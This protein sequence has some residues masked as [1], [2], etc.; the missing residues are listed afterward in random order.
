M[1]KWTIALV[2]LLAAPAPADVIDRVAI[3]VGRHVITE[4]Q[5]DEEILVTAFLNE[6]PISRDLPSRRAAADRLIEQFLIQ[7]ELETS[8]YPPPAAADVDA[9]RAKVQS[10]LGGATSFARSLQQYGLSESILHEHLALQLTILRFV[11]S[12]FQSDLPVTDAEIEMFY[13]NEL[14]KAGTDSSIVPTPSS[15]S[16]DSV[17]QIIAE[18]HTDAALKAWLDD[19]RRRFAIVFLDKS[20]Q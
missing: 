9:Y 19:A 12:R 1:H 14:L 2:A 13:T 3:A 15:K 20:L 7:R 10:Q 17:R 18:Q 16:R 11:E 8:H 6:K 5:L 4:T